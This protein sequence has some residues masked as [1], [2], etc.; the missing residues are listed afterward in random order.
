MT[1]NDVAVADITGKLNAV[2]VDGMTTRTEV[3]AATQQV[4]ED[5][6]DF[7]GQLSLSADL[8]IT[9]GFISNAT[10][11]ANAEWWSVL[12]GNGDVGNVTTFDPAY[13][14]AEFWNQSGYSLQQTTHLPAGKYRLTARAMTRTGMTA[15]LSAAGE[16]TNITG[17]SSNLV[18]SRS[19]AG[20]YFDSEMGLNTLEF[21]LDS[22]SE[23]T[24]QLKADSDNGDH[25]LIWRN[26]TL[27]RLYDV[28]TFMPGDV[29]NSGSVSIADVTALVNIV[30][31]KDSTK[32]YQYNHD[33]AD[34][35]GNGVISIADVTTLVNKI[36]GKQ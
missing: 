1:G 20:S 33:A 4:R 32:P 24:I 16:S 23:V 5:A 34:V 2:D 30:L 13:N 14:V 35:D 28:P 26:F 7:L 18:D 21:T 29:D 27:T 11:T 36:L 17:A 9:T 3:Q 19:A 31:G 25:W 22:D 10:P 8:D 12:D 15:T 6:A